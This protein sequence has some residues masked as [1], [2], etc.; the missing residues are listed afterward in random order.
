MLSVDG[1]SHVI[2]HV[3]TPWA[4]G[5]SKSCAFGEILKMCLIDSTL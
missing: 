4:L 1:K 3:M 2:Y 5:N